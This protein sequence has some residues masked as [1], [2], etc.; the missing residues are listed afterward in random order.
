MQASDI[1][2]PDLRAIVAK[3]MEFWQRPLR[4]SA[5]GK[6]LYLGALVIEVGV[7][8]ALLA[9]AEFSDFLRRVQSDIDVYSAASLEA[10]FKLAQQGAHRLPGVW[11]ND[12]T[13]PWHLSCSGRCSPFGRSGSGPGRCRRTGS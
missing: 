12:E 6:F 3:G 10:V 8:A 4:V 1:T 9:R 2:Q 5:H 11:Q 7:P 13:S